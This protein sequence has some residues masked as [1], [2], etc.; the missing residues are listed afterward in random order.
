MPTTS[1]AAEHE[2]GRLL[3]Y[4]RDLRGKS[5]LAMSFDVG[6]SQ[7]HLSFIESGRSTP[8]RPTLLA[9]ADALAVPLRERNDL[10]LAAGYA[11][12]YREDSWNA[13]EMH[14]VRRALERMLQ[15]HEPFPAL[16]LDRYWNVVMRNAAA[17]R[18]FKH[19]IDLD[20][21]PEPR[22][23]L[24]LMFDPAAMRPFVRNWADTSRALLQRVRREAVGHH[25][26]E[27]MQALLAQLQAYPDAPEPVPDSEQTSRAAALPLI[28]VSFAWQGH[29]LNYFSMIS[30][31]G[32]PHSITAEELRIESM[33]PADDA[34]EQTHCALFAPA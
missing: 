20:A 21:W 30:T 14:S 15:Q 28:P 13:E 16:V 26:D 1:H 9:I 31:V 34:T 11:P 5:Q 25:V 33:F 6:V 17:Q 29:A 22:N 23:L 32:T 7:R 27:T 8:S 18:F 24:H 12:H 3:R 4:W 19:F 2:L 10:L